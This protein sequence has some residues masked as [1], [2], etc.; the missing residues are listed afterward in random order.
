MKIFI[1]KIISIGKHFCVMAG[2]KTTKDR[3]HGGVGGMSL[4]LRIWALLASIWV[5]LR[6]LPSLSLSQ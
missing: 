3:N 2:A 1:S 4:V 6:A 5:S